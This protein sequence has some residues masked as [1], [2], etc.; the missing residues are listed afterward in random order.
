MTV[1]RLAAAVCLALCLGAACTS[2]PSAN[3]QAG[4]QPLEVTGADRAM[5]E[6]FFQRN[7]AAWNAHDPVAMARFNWEDAT[8]VNY[9]GAFSPDQ[10]TAIAG[11]TAIHKTFYSASVV[12]NEIEL[13]RK[14]TPDVVI[15]V[16]RIEL[17]G[18]A[19]RPGFVFHGRGTNVLTRR[20]GEWR[21]AAFQ[22]TQL[23]DGVN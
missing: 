8:A 20:N 3:I 4:H 22:N 13:V 5:F 16:T 21:V 1:K 2:A 14:I 11:L 12:K 15:V 6:T 9:V 18:D 17:T 7:D 19:R 23:A 10:K